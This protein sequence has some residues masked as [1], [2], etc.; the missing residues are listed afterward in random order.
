MMTGRVTRK[1]ARHLIARLTMAGQ[2]ERREIVTRFE[3]RGVSRAWY[4]LAECFVRYER[5]SEREG[6]RDGALGAMKGAV[7][8]KKA[9]EIKDS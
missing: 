7:R 1:M 3:S 5:T 2:G 4:D 9:Y 6:R 8:R